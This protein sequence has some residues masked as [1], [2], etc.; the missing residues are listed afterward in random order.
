MRGALPE[1]ISLF[2]NKDLNFLWNPFLTLIAGFASP[3]NL[4]IIS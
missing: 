4:L 1:E 2:F 3:E